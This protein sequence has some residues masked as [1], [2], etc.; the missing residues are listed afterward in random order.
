MIIFHALT[1]ESAA[2]LT[3]IA[4]QIDLD[5]KQRM[6][7]FGYVSRVVVYECDEWQTSDRRTQPQ[8]GDGVDRRARVW[9]LHMWR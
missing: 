3:P 6:F 9:W 5:A 7:E 4:P 8:G 2:S 1:I